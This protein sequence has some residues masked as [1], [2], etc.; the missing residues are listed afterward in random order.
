M[1]CAVQV[2]KESSDSATYA[3]GL[4]T[5]ATAEA[6][7]TSSAGRKLMDQEAAAGIDR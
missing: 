3:Y 5:V 4:A 6:P 1:T 2:L 7:V